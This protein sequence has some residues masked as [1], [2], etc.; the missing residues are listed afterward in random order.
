MEHNTQLENTAAYVTDFFQEHSNPDLTYHNL[1][2]TQKVVKRVKEIALN[3]PF[4]P[5]DIFVLEVAAWFHD[6]GQLLS[7]GQGHEAI[8][9]T[10]MKEYVQKLYTDTSMVSK[11]EQCIL[12]TKTPHQPRSFLDM[13]ICD[14]DTYNLGT[15][16]FAQTDA[17]LKREYELRGLP[18]KDWDENTLK[19]L[20]QHQYHTSYCKAN[21][22]DGKRANIELV[23]KRSTQF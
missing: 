6:T 10:I 11:I 12:A 13:V 16:E 22:S 19:F 8:S 15:D 1:E 4:M 14:A 21:L 7:H 20:L 17:L 3:Y 18:V 5:N 9:V 2:H 23:R